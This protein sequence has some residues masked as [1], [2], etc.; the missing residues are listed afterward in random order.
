MNQQLGNK[1]CSGQLS[2]SRGK[3]V[4]GGQLRTSR[5]LRSAEVCMC[6]A[7]ARPSNA[8]RPSRSQGA[9]KRAPLPGGG[10]HASHASHV[11]HTSHASH[12][13]H[14]SGVL[15]RTLPRHTESPA[16]THWSRTPS[17]TW[18]RSRAS[19]ELHT[20]WSHSQHP[21]NPLS[22]HCICLTFLTSR[23]TGVFLGSGSHD[24]VHVV[25]DD[26]VPLVPQE[27][28]MSGHLLLALLL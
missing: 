22:T 27:S 4:F 26:D 16:K 5:R 6:L 13:S 8:A 24:S 11:S 12:A 18:E 3:A 15:P 19:G 14:A 25:A 23:T 20:A 9:G 1:S 2:L 17:T 28:P 21:Q 7:S 10:P